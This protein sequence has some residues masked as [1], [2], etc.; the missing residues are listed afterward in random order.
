M[1]WSGRHM[2]PQTFFAQAPLQHCALIMQKVPSGEHMP[3]PHRPL[4]QK[5]PQHWPGWMQ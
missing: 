3:L 1:D 5:P 2:P 4:S